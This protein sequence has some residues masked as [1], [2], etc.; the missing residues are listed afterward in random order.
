[1]P[2]QSDPN[3]SVQ[4]QFSILSLHA[5]DLGKMEIDQQL[6]CDRYTLTRRAQPTTHPPHLARVENDTSFQASIREVEF[7][8]PVRSFA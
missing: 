5:A 4:R 3:L 7:H 6:G 1:M 2:L 8:L